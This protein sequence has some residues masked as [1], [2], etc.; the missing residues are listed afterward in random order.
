MRSK[1]IPYSEFL[2][3]IF[4]QKMNFREPYFG[5]KNQKNE[6]LETVF[7]KITKNEFLETVNLV[8]NY[9]IERGVCQVV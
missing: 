1:K 3:T 7:P 8:D 5:L 6:F 4:F 2:E 9:I